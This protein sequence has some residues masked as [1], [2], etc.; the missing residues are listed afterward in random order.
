MTNEEV[1]QTA[2]WVGIVKN[3]MYNFWIK[4]GLT[5]ELCDTSNTLE[6]TR[7]KPNLCNYKVLGLNQLYIYN[8]L[9]ENDF[10]NLGIDEAPSDV[11]EYMR[12]RFT[13]FANQLPITRL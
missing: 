2:F 5:K 13:L 7:N 11:L 10:N 9:K 6:L 12:F 1:N 4:I 8:K 3:D